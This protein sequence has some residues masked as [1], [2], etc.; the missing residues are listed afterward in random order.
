MTCP[1]SF[2]LPRTGAG[3]MSERASNHAVDFTRAVEYLFTTH[4]LA[5]DGF[6]SDGLAALDLDPVPPL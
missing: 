6:F 2:V 4:L 3:D 5:P 1:G